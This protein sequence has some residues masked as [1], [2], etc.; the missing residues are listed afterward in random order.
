MFEFS[1]LNKTWVLDVDGTMTDA[2]L[3]YDENGNEVKKF[4]TRDAAGI[5][6]AKYVGI[7]VMV[8]TGREC[9][10]TRRRM[11]ELGVDYLYQNVREKDKFLE[12]FMREK[13]FIKT[14]VCYV[15]D[16]LN[17]IKAMKLCE[18]IACP[19]DCCK[20][21]KKI[22]SYVSYMDGGHG[23]V[24]DVVEN[25]LLNTACEWDYAVEAVYGVGL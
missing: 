18:Y 16:D 9:N 14:D 17:D 6:V 7:K 11:K 12:E 25:Y 4:C 24:R 3:Y 20:E 13:H 23:V 19:A 1:S 15:G 21:V 8:L 2:G 10:A 22:A 5:V